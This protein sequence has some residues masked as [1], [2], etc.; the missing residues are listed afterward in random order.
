MTHEKV[1]T[2][3]LVGWITAVLILLALFCA[4]DT[5]AYPNSGTY[6][7]V[8]VQLMSD[9]MNISQAEGII[10]MYPEEYWK[11]LE[12]LRIQK[13]SYCSQRKIKAYYWWHARMI[14]TCYFDKFTI[15]HEL[16]HHKQKTQGETWNEARDHIGNFLIYYKEI[17]GDKIE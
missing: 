6:K 7:G 15:A 9:T 14:E 8:K 1:K 3:L 2:I 4:R 16:A 5:L 11:G 12:L 17:L 13:Q 10:N